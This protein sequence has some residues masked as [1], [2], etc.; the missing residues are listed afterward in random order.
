ME[1]KEYKS[2]IEW[3]VEDLGKY[4]KKI[5]IAVLWY[6]TFGNIYRYILYYISG[7]NSY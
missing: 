2:L 7:G 3:F 6:N 5:G 1:E 4:K